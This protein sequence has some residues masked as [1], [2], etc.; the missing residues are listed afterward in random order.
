MSPALTSHKKCYLSLNQTGGKYGV[1]PALTSHK[2]YYVYVLRSLKD[3]KLYVGFT[4]ELQ[5]RIIEHNKGNVFS[6]KSRVPFVLEYY[7]A[8]RDK[9][10]AVERERQLKQQGQAMRRLKDRM[11]KNQ[12]NRPT[13]WEVSAG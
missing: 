8:F 5:R 4:G 12:L 3:G 7:E 13:K 2:M 10:S 9:D 1:N 6:T 11:L